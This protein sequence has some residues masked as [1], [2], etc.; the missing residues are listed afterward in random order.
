MRKSRRATPSRGTEPSAHKAPSAQTSEPASPTPHDA[1][2]KATFSKIEHAGPML[3]AVLP[4]DLSALVAWSTLRRRPGS[5]VNEE[6]R[7]HHTDLLFSAKL[8][9]RTAYLYLLFEHQSTADRWMPLRI[10]EYMLRIW[11]EHLACR[12]RA[13]RLPAILPVVLHHSAS[14]W[15]CATAFEELLDLDDGSRPTVEPF[16]PRFRIL[17]DDL[18]HAT[19]DELRDRAVTDLTKLVLCSLHHARDM[20]TFLRTF[21]TWNQTL[22]RILAAPHGIHA[23][24]LVLEYMFKVA[25]DLS[26]GEIR[27][28]VAGIQNPVVVEEV[29]TLAEKLKDEGMQE[30]IR[31]GRKQ[32]RTEIILKQLRL[33]FGQLPADVVKRVQTAAKKELDRWTERVLTETSLEAVL[34]G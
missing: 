2:F 5:F 16:V 33:K 32:E 26:A 25:R 20:R 30:G 15:T 3:R 12:T 34:D 31:R 17:L 7:E 9:G 13:R 22:L 23:L 6:L 18:S 14:G 24:R 19:D 1:L 21:H 4:K 11:R 8:A 27:Q 28:L 10:L 29:V